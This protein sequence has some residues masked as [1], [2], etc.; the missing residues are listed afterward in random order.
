MERVKAVR[1]FRLASKKAATRRRADTPTLFAEDRFVDAPALLVSMVSAG[2]RHYAPVGFVDAGVVPSNLIFFAPNAELYHFGVLT[3]SIHMAWMR[4][5]A[6][7]LGTSYRYSVQVVYN[8]FPWVAASAK[9]RAKIEASAQAI[10]DVRARYAKATLAD[11]Y[12]ELTMPKDLRAA[13]RAND[14]AVAAAYGFE[15]ILDDEAAL[16]AELFKL[17]TSLTNA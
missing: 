10:L 4:T 7:Y 11:L 1:D 6:G 13:H 14:K 9:A 8:T 3:S 16:V 5:L 15:G 17:Y 2:T 12:D